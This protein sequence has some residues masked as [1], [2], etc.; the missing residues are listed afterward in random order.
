MNISL[1]AID[2]R[3]EIVMIEHVIVAISS[4]IKAL[5]EI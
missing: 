5:I 1:K 3:K 4:D 2:D